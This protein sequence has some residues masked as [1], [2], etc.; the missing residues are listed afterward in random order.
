MKGTYLLIAYVI[1][2]YLK[3]SIYPAVKSLGYSLDDCPIDTN[4]LTLTEYID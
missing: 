4:Q 3:N 1:N 2:E